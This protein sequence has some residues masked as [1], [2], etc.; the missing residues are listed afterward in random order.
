MLLC[1]TQY[2]NFQFSFPGGNWHFRVGNIPET[3]IS[4]ESIIVS[5]A[6]TR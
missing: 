5:G 2:R 4:V 3:G 1:I 6:E